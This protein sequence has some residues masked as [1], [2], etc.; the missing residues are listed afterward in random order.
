MRNKRTLLAILL[1]LAMTLSLLPVTALTDYLAEYSAK[2]PLFDNII[3]ALARDGKAYVVP[4][5]ISVPKIA[6]AAD[7]ME[8]VTSLH[9]HLLIHG[10]H[11][12]TSYQYM[13]D[14]SIFPTPAKYI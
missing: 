7:G 1:V 6:A 12:N 2:E 5:A 14:I 11:Q 10:S 8:N 13:I 3:D 4:A 9:F